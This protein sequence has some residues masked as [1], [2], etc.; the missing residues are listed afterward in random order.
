MSSRSRGT[1][2]NHEDFGG[3][4]DGRVEQR[5]AVGL[6]DPKKDNQVLRRKL[7]R[8]I[9]DRRRSC[10]VVVEVPGGTMKILE[11]NATDELN[12]DVP[13]AGRIQNTV[14]WCSGENGCVRFLIFGVIDMY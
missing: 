12:I 10:P 9:F 13:R 2:W 6:G 4:R 3:E 8:Q 11:E 14:I 1:G 5:C 7:P